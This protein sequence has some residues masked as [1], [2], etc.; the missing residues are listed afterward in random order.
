MFLK[1][2]QKVTMHVPMTNNEVD[3]DVGGFFIY[4]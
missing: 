1:Y 4:N 2:Q 3:K